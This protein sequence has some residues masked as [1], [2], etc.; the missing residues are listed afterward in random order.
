MRRRFS[1]VVLS[2]LP[3]RAVSDHL[4]GEE[5]AGPIRRADEGPGGHV[6][7]AHRLARLPETVEFLRT[8]ELLYREVPA[9]RTQ[10][11]AQGHD[12]HA[13]RAKIGRASCRGR[14]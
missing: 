4:L 2:P 13:G 14:V 12:V 10:V 5:L 6:G 8:H 9:A 7:E 1:S 3:I 11:L